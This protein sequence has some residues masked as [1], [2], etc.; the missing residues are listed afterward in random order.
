MALPT[1]DTEDTSPPPPS[2]EDVCPPR[3]LTSRCSTSRTRTLLTSLSGFP[4]TSSLP[5][6][7]SP[8][9]DS[10]WPSL[11]SE[12]LPLS[13]RCSSVSESNSPPCSEE[14]PSS[15]AESNMND[16]VSEYQQYQDATAE[17]EEEME[18]E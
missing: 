12:T 7:I 8:P 16:L 1:P 13:R 17:D 6:V 3:R 9:R 4:T 2:S 15:E 5:S 10:R 11:S 14:R 18:D